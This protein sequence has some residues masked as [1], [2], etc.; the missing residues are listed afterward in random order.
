MYVLLSITLKVAGIIP[1]NYPGKCKCGYEF[2]NNFNLTEAVCSNPYGCPTESAFKIVNMLNILGVKCGIGKE[3]CEDIAYNALNYNHHLDIFS[4]SDL[5]LKECRTI[6]TTRV[7]PL[8]Y[9]LEKINASGGIRL[10]T[11]ISLFNFDGLGESYCN[12][13]FGNY[14]NL[15]KFYKEIITDNSRKLISNFIGISPYTDTVINID[16]ILRNNKELIYKYINKFIIK[17]SHDTSISICITGAI[18]RVLDNE[19]N[20]F[21]PRER[22]AEYLSDRFK[23]NFNIEKT[24]SNNVRYVI[25]DNPS[26]SRK[27]KKAGDRLVKSDELIKIL[28]SEVFINGRAK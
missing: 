24:A 4:L 13:I 9:E 20:F 28:E 5:D 27:E 14:D 8:I 11:Y 17:S 10:S 21:K 23:I 1:Y 12:K 25:C 16:K 7:M 6:T 3:I 26:G 18:T 19:G 22:F 2:K 15:D